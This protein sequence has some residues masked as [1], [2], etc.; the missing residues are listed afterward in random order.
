MYMGALP[1]HAAQNY[2]KVVTTSILFNKV[3]QSE[4]PLIMRKIIY[5]QMRIPTEHFEH[6]PV[7]TLSPSPISPSSKAQLFTYERYTYILQFYLKK[8]NR[9]LYLYLTIPW[10]WP[11]DLDICIRPRCERPFYILK[12][13]PW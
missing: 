3:I 11:N 6:I 9:S 13:D 4:I 10:Y 2:H 5:L 12:V 1:V 8:I 7:Y